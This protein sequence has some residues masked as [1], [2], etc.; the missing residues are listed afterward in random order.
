MFHEGLR[1]AWLIFREPQPG[2]C[3]ELSEHDAMQ[4]NTRGVWMEGTIL[5]MY[6]SGRVT[7]LKINLKPL[8]MDNY[9]RWI[10]D[11]PTSGTRPWIPEMGRG[12]WSVTS[13]TGLYPQL[14][15]NSIPV[16][17]PGG[18]ISSP[19]V[20]M[21]PRRLPCGSH[22]AP[23]YQRKTN[24]NKRPFLSDSWWPELAQQ[25]I[26]QLSCKLCKLHLDLANPQKN[27]KPSHWNQIAVVA[28]CQVVPSQLGSATVRA[29]ANLRRDGQASG[30][31]Q[32]ELN[33]VGK[34]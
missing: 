9:P 32:L 7:L 5:H 31:R 3:I 23:K 22:M 17:Y 6:R 1:F 4:G 13:T 8:Y 11:N 27:T 18:M 33:I 16:R 30:P 2:R 29:E 15:K 21:A 20:A 25:R 14:P 24:H 26:T 34:C 28:T 19:Q 10:H 12:Q